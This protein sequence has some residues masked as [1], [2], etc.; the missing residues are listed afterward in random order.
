MIVRIDFASD[1]DVGVVAEA[2]VRELENA[3]IVPGDPFERHV[4]TTAEIVNMIQASDRGKRAIMH[5]VKRL[6]DRFGPGAEVA[7]CVGNVNTSIVIARR[8]IVAK[9][10][11]PLGAAEK[12][13][14]TNLFRSLGDGKL[15]VSGS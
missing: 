13:T 7:W 11:R 14:L 1:H 3:V 15:F 8:H 6:K 12:T 10:D 2:L 5:S 4:A 9:S